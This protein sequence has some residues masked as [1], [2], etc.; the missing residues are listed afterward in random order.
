MKKLEK[1]NPWL[2]LACQTQH[3][4]LLMA[5]ITDNSS[6]MTD[7]SLGVDGGWGSSQSSTLASAST[8]T[9]APA[10]RRPRLSLDPSDVQPFIDRL[11]PKSAADGASLRRSWAGINHFSLAFRLDCLTPE[12]QTRMIHHLF[13]D[14]PVSD[15]TV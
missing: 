10:V 6:R 9:L 14:V 8:S 15:V 11:S 1:C 2:D 7:A 12:S 3:S 13:R 5:K 4:Q